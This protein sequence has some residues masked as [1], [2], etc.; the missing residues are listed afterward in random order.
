MSDVEIEAVAKRMGLTKDQ[1]ADIVLKSAGGNVPDHT[2][3]TSYYEKYKN[4][5][6]MLPNDIKITFVYRMS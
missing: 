5:P 6:G 2:E 1:L 4:V 3:H